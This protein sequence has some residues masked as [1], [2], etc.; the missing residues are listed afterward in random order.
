MALIYRPTRPSLSI[1]HLYF[2]AFRPTR[3]IITRIV[4][5]GS[6]AL[7][8]CAP[9]IR[10]KTHDRKCYTRFPGLVIHRLL[11]FVISFPPSLDPWGRDTSGKSK[12]Y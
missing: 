10:L 2:E 12:A 8:K 5:C 7:R 3:A 9:K 4:L 1:K 6:Q 11:D